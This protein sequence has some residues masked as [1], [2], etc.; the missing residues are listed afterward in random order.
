[1]PPR[2]LITGSRGWTDRAVIRDA[3]R[4]WWDSTG[5]DPEA[6]LVSGKCPKGADRICEEI[7]A[8]NG[9]TLELHPAKWRKADGSQDMAAGYTR[10]K[11]MVDTRPDHLIAFIL[12]K[13][14]GASHCLRYA[15]K[16][17]IPTTVYEATTAVTD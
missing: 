10:N 4:D 14:G 9:L 16:Q 7:W 3:L 8:H 11:A 12:D 13:S 2:L 15:Q 1:M 5:R 17:G 6:I